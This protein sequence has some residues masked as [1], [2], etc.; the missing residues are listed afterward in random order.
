[1]KQVSIGLLFSEDKSK[2][3][4]M[5]RYFPKYG[6]TQLLTGIGGNLDEGEDFYDAMFREFI[7]EAGVVVTDWDGFCTINKQ[8]DG[9]EIT[10]EFFRA[11][12]DSIFQATTKE[13]DTVLIVP[14]LSLIEYQ[15]HPN[16]TF[17]IHLALCSEQK[18]VQINYL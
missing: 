8:E 5:K 15:K 1:M 3:L 7:E 6:I 9:E 17:L 14:V 16:L 18:T 12:S 11:F 2:V 13:D 10:I 4:L